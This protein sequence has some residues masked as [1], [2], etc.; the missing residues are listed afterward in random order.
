[1]SDQPDVDDDLES[2]RFESFYEREYTGTVRLAGFLS[3]DRSI[4][5]VKR[6]GI[7]GGSSP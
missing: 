2:S 4:A 1:M 6:P 5:E 7:R 3:G